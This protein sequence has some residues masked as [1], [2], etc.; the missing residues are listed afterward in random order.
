VIIDTE[1]KD[2]MFVRFEGWNR[3]VWVQ[4]RNDPHYVVK[5]GWVPEGAPLKT[6][7]KDDFKGSVVKRS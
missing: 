1:E 3:W 2:R 7:K 5:R 6:C 4:K